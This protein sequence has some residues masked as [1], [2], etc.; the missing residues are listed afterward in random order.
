MK[1]KGTQV[2]GEVRTE[3]HYGRTCGW[4]IE[5]G[6]EDGWVAVQHD[7]MDPPMTTFPILPR[8]TGMEFQKRGVHPVPFILQ[9]SHFTLSLIH[10]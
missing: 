6:K 10:I 3:E 9:L 8:V 5:V 1:R 2:H 4:S 7:K